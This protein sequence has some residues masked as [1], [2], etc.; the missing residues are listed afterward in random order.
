MDSSLSKELREL[1]LHLESL[2]SQRDEAV[3]LLNR[4]NEEI[5]DLRHQIAGLQ[6][7]LHKK[8]L[9][10]EYLTVSPKLADTPGALYDARTT[11]RRM[12]T[13]VEKAIALLK[14][15]ARI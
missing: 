10:V 15:D 3:S 13:R 11:V 4:A 6:E 2:A 7:E 9:D 5:S 12:L 8:N 1:A 14:E